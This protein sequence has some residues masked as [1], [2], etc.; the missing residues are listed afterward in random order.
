MSHG[1]FKT[2][3][4]GTVCRIYKNSNDTVIAIDDIAVV[5]DTTRLHQLEKFHLSARP[6][7]ARTL[8][9]LETANRTI[10]TIQVFGN[11]DTVDVDG[12]DYTSATWSGIEGSSGD[13]VIDF[14]H[15]PKV[16]DTI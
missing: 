8:F 4:I 7:H 16:G 6:T 10:A 2:R 13:V 3:Q 1:S 15:L 5:A 11:F 12:G 9:Y 14:K